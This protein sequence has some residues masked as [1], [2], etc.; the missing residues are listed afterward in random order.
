MADSDVFPDALNE[1]LADPG[2][3]VIPNDEFSRPANVSASTL[4]GVAGYFDPS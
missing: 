3:W 1:L 4:S 2:M